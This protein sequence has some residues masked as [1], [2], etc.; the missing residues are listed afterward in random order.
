MRHWILLSSFALICTVA[1]AT[2]VRAQESDEPTQATITLLE[3]E[4]SRLPDRASG[5]AGAS[6]LE[7]ALTDDGVARSEDMEIL[8]RLLQS[9][10][11]EQYQ[12][13]PGVVSAHP[14]W[15]Q[16]TRQAADID[17]PNAVYLTGYGTVFTADAPALRNPQSTEKVETEFRIEEIDDWEKARRLLRGKKVAEYPFTSAQSTKQCKQCHTSEALSRGDGRLDFDS[18]ATLTSSQFKA[19][20]HPS[21]TREQITDALVETLAEHGHRLRGLAPDERVTIALTLRDPEK[22][23][24]LQVQT[25]SMFSTSQSQY[26]TYGNKQKTELIEL[27]G[28][29]V[30]SD[31]GIIGRVILDASS[32]G[33]LHL[34]Q[35]NYEKAVNEY[36]KSLVGLVDGDLYAQK[37]TGGDKATALYKKLIQAHV[38]AGQYDK[39]QKLLE[40]VERSSKKELEGRRS[41]VAT[42]EDRQLPLPGRLIV[43]A[44]KEALDQVAS[45]S[46]SLKEFRE[47][48]EIR[49][50]EP[51]PATHAEIKVRTY[52]D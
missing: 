44:T 17:S 11:L 16:G 49:Y 40:L 12:W 47:A 19:A 50:S 42:G 36:M 25:S 3:V 33:D 34:R 51:R 37:E 8:G 35:G 1:F 23:A 45:G 15:S 46:M 38:G 21:P 6:L 14:H 9:A 18:L 30:N 48:C 20:P 13:P 39:A 24:S 10:L 32:P 43:S 5:R 22:E 4:S 27:S 29:G 2:H 52:Q 31:A 26:P 7:V 28:V 41:I